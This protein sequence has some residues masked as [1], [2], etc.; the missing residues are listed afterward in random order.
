MTLES[1]KSEFYPIEASEVPESEAVAQSL[2][3]WI[4]LRKENLD[5][6]ECFLDE[7]GVVDVN[8]EYLMINAD[9]C[10]LCSYYQLAGCGIC[11]LSEAGYGC[12]L[13]ESPWD[14]FTEDNS[15]VEPMIAALTEISKK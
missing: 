13:Y 1:W 8:G 10:A 9:S 5:K 2:Q 6:H 11:P 14:K 7:F 3:K 12:E 4:G 15:N